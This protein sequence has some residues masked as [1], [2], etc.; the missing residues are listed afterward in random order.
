M[1]L[2][3]VHLFASYADSFGASQVKIE[4][5]SRTTVADLITELR[6]RPGAYVLPPSPRVAVNQK[7]AGPDQIL[8]PEDEIALIPPVAG[9]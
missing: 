5:P 9:G 8:L 6:S 3:T 2:V 7:F 1:S 4:L